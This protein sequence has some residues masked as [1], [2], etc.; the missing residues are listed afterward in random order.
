MAEQLS[1]IERAILAQLRVNHGSRKGRPSNRRL[2]LLAQIA[3][4]ASLIELKQQQ[5]AKS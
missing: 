3:A 1:N 5:K 2:K 4:L